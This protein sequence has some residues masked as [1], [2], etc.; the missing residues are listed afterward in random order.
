MVQIRSPSHLS[1]LPLLSQQLRMLLTCS[2]QPPTVF[3]ILVLS[4]LFW[5][6]ICHLVCILNL[7]PTY[8]PSAYET[9]ASLLLKN[10]TPSLDPESRM[11][12]TVLSL[13]SHLLQSNLQ[14]LCLLTL[15]ISQLTEIRLLPL[16]F[17]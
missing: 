16:L 7:S 2:N 4:C 9:W 13:I 8:Y 5:N 10:K 1:L 12:A 17:H 11:T 6:L 15:V 3:I 14:M